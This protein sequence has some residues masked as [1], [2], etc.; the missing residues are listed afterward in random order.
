MQVMTCCEEAK[1]RSRSRCGVC[2]KWIKKRVLGTP[3]EETKRKIGESRRGKPGIPRSEE[4]RRKMSEAHK[5]RVHAPMTQE[6]R[7][8]KSASMKKA[9]AEGRCTETRAPYKKSGGFHNG[10]WMRCL[11]SEGVFAR[12]LDEAGIK[13]VYEPRRFNTSLGS[14]LP[15]FYLP[16]FNIYVDIK[17]TRPQ[18]KNF[19]KMQAFREEFG[20]CLVVIYQREL[21]RMRY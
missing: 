20:K 21:G 7:D 5:G 10:V 1:A 9:W 12:L 11:N 6:T 13:W 3:S 8:K 17:G 19:A 18:A 2:K 15:D 14:Y 16:E 4:T